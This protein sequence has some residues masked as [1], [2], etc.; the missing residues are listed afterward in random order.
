MRRA[1]VPPA[2][3]AGPGPDGT[4]HLEE[5]AGDVGRD[6]AQG[7]VGPQDGGAAIIELGHGVERMR[8]L[9]EIEKV[10][11]RDIAPALLVQLH[12]VDDAFGVI[13]GQLPQQQ[14]VDHR[15]DGGVGA[16]AQR[17]RQHSHHGEAR[18]PAPAIATRTSGRVAARRTVRRDGGCGVRGQ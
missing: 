4:H 5:I 6:D 18:A 1:R 10:G 17:Q 7:L 11:P 9:L 15:E 16:D 3:A 12:H 13:V 2:T 8:L 14:A